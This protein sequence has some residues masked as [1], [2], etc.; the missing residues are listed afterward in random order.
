[1]KTLQE[2]RQEHLA[3]AR[4]VARGEEVQTPV[5]RSPAFKALVDRIRQ[6]G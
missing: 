4:R 5:T 2:I 1:M 3:L 6:D